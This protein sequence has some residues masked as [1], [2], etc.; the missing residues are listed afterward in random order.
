[1]ENLKTT[2]LIMRLSEFTHP[3]QIYALAEKPYLLQN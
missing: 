2:Y 1:L 3:N